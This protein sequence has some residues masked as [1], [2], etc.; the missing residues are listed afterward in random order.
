MKTKT[1]L[2]FRFFFRTI[3]GVFA[4]FLVLSL[5]PSLSGGTPSIPIEEQRHFVNIFKAGDTNAPLLAMNWVSERVDYSCYLSQS[6]N[7]YSVISAIQGGSGASSKFA[8][9]STNRPLLFAA[10]NSLPASSKKSLPK[11]RQIWVSG[12]RSNQWFQF[13]YDRANIPFEVEKLYQI[14]GAEL[15]WFIPQ[16]GWSPKLGEHMMASIDPNSFY[17]ARD[18]DFAVSRCDG[19]NLQIWNLN[20]KI[21]LKNLSWDYL[22][23]PLKKYVNESGGITAISS[24][25]RVLIFAVRNSLFAVD[26]RNQKLLW[27]TDHFWGN[28]YHADEKTMAI[29]NQDQSLFVAELNS[30]EHR[31]LANGTKI[32]TLVTNNTA[33]KFLKTSWDG[34]V[35]V[36]GFADN[37]FTIWKTDKDKPVANFTEPDGA[38]CIAIS[39]DGKK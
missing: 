32:G 16:V 5:C 8:L 12:M 17:I 39:P 24:D 18:T 11:E 27:E 35:L 15:K 10:I 13:V 29:G 22:P 36:G 30:I 21:D 37:S 4:V 14:T 3:F 26:W 33:I 1:A 23:Y 2:R 7:I 28:T 34:K 25:G 6:G 20:E 31:S 19:P 38:N 9:D